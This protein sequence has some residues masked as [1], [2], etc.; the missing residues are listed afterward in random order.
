MQTK[1]VAEMT[2]KEWC[3]TRR[4]VIA[5]NDASFGKV[6]QDFEDRL[7]EAVSHYLF[8]VSKDV[9]DEDASLYRA[10]ALRLISEPVDPALLAEAS[11]RASNDDPLYN[12]ISSPNLWELWSYH[13]RVEIEAAKCAETMRAASHNGL[14]D[15]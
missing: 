1:P 5:F 2:F 7:A 6:D 14:G 10:A 12:H 13:H 9:P 8:L 15:T 3:D 4:R 11:K